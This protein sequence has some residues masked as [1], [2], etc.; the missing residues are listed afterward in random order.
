MEEDSLI[1]LFV[2]GGVVM[3]GLI[4][5]AVMKYSARARERRRQALE[6]V[7]SQVGGQVKI[8]GRWA[9]PLLTWE[10]HGLPAALMFYSTG[11]QHPVYYTRLLYTLQE[12]PAFRLKIYPEGVLQKLGKKLGGQDVASGDPRFDETFMVKS[13]DEMRAQM[14]IG[15]TSVREALLGLR[16][17]GKSKHLVVE[18]QKQGVLQVEKMSWIEAPELLRSLV[19]LGD[20]VLAGFLKAAR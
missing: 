16:E 12:P 13:S 7:A 6:L 19:A 3:V 15:D 4:L 10:S 2:A 14:V 18:T 17:L 9:E 20:Q 5:F 8:P 1:V 11:G